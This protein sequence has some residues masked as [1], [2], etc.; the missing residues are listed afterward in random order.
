MNI[1]EE[2]HCI[3]PMTRNNKNIIYK[4]KTYPVNFDTIKNNSNYF[5]QN[6]KKFQAENIELQIEIEIPLDTIE[7]FISCCQNKKFKINESNVF[8]LDYL[9]KKYDVPELEKI[10]QEYISKSNTDLAFQSLLF[11]C[12]FQAKFDTSNEEKIIGHRLKEYLNDERLIK[13]PI[14]TLDRIL[15]IYLKEN[16]NEKDI[17][18]INEFLFKCLDL[19]ERKASILFLNI[20]IENQPKNLIIRLLNDYSNIFDFNM[21]NLQSILNTSSELLKE[22]IK[23]KIEFESKI[24]EMNRIISEQK[25][26]INKFNEARNLIDND[27]KVLI[28]KQNK[29]IEEQQNEIREFMQKQNQIN[30]PKHNTKKKIQIQGNK[31]KYNTKTW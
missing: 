6:S 31:H 1:Q 27:F 5:F 25:E 8:H 30:I 16:K 23:V 19:H 14:S 21:I 11:K 9:S 4:S 24:S 3:G 2:E 7:S 26:E 18:E 28:Q 22:L 10:T 29:I 12:Q 20:N 13:L 15:K 17:N